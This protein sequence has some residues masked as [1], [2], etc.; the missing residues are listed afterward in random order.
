[1]PPGEKEDAISLR[2]PENCYNRVLAKPDF[3][4]IPRSNV[5]DRIKDFLGRANSLSEQSSGVSEPII[6][7]TTNNY[8]NNEYDGPLG[9]V[10]DVIGIGPTESPGES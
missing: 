6:L 2:L 9:V 4:D 8:L 10:M 7:D 1:M 3:N 5:K